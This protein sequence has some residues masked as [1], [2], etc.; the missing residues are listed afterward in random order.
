MNDS[1]SADAPASGFGASTLGGP[2][3]AH[4]GALLREA[5]EAQGLHPAALA[6][7][8]KVPVRQIE[9]LEDDRLDLLPDLVFARALAA[10]VCR[11]L[12]IDPQPVLA[13]LPQGQPRLRKEREPINEPFR[14]PGQSGGQS[15]REQLARPPVLVALALLLGAIVLLALPLFQGGAGGQGA[16]APAA[17]A[18]VSP[19]PVVPAAPSGVVTESVTPTLPS[20][21]AAPAVPG[22]PAGSG[23]AATPGA[24]GAPATPAAPGAERLPPVV[25]ALPAGPSASR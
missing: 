20:G 11:Q 16:P 6:V 17:S 19:V 14:T 2:P 9:A 13:R 22:A 18:A 3:T 21:T 7:A 8:L 12:R 1:V 23:A 25:P 4:A 24:P 10:S 5:R 15:W